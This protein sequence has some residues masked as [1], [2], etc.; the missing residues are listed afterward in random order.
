MA[1]QITP[2]N[3]QRDQIFKDRYALKDREGNLLETCPGQM[4]DRVAG[5]FAEDPEQYERFRGV[6][7][8]FQFVPS[9]RVLSGAKAGQAVTYYNCFVLGLR[10]GDPSKGVD[11]RHSIMNTMTR[12]VEINARGGGVG[13]NWSAL[14]PAGA[15]IKGVHGQSSGAHQWMWGADG[16]A[17]QIRQGGSRTAALMFLL[18]DWHPD[19]LEFVNPEKRFE[20]ANFSV[21]VSDAFMKAVKADGTWDLVFPDTSHRNYDSVWTGDIKAWKS[22][23]YPILQYKQIRARD[24]WRAMCESAYRIGSPGVVFL[25]RAD[26]ASNTWYVEKLIGTNPCGEQAL[27]ADGSCNLGSINLVAMW[28]PELEEINW[29]RLAHAVEVGVEF[30]DRVIDVGVDIDQDIGDLQRKIRRIGLGTMGLADLLILQGYEYG[31]GSANGAIDFLFYFIK[32]HAYRASVRLAKKKGPAPGL[33]DVRLY[34]GGSFILRLPEDL[35]DEIAE[36]GIRNMQV[37]TQAPTGT[38]SILAG[39]SS[40]IEPNFRGSYVRTDATGTHLV[41]HPLWKRYSGSPALVT[42]SDVSIEGHIKAQAAI[43]R[44]VDSC[45]SKTI[46]MPAGATVQDIEN[47]YLKAYDLGCKGI[48]VYRDGSLGNVLTEADPSVCEACQV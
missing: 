48:T 27:P 41:Q 17:N 18:E 44:H 2:W 14:R 7:Q 31:S 24:L 9:G 16:L 30:L 10:P 47:A 37:L 39:V 36:H 1:Y 6:L 23:G 32:V 42:A 11:S 33:G 35:R 20:R 19:I 46:N 38:T 40:G 21:A 8:D 34:L 5:A 45:I 29:D 26:R 28:D 12:M 4:W 22:S 3:S 15:Y 25:D 43:Q 13:I